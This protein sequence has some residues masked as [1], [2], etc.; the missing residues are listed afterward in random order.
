MVR[1]RLLESEQSL[2][3]RVD[4]NGASLLFMGDLEEDGIGLLLSYYTGAARQVLDADVLQVGHHGSNNAT[5]QALLDTIT[6]SV[7]V[8]N[9][10]KWNYGQPS[11]P[12][13]TFLY[14]HPRQSTLDLL[15]ASITRKRSQSKSVM[16]ANGS[17]NFHSTTVTKAI[18]ATGW[19]G[20]V[21][22]VV[23]GKDDIRL[24]GTLTQGRIHMGH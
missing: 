5:T 6:P 23:K 7:A 22:V 12:F 3:T 20:T 24:S 2:V 11:K 1:R 9:V 10:G 18:Y 17:K 13:T 19:D 16:A 8:I 15:S 4:F 21:R 14:G